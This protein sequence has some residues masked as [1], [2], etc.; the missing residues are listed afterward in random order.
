MSP[1][2]AQELLTRLN[3][4]ES[5]NATLRQDQGQARKPDALS[6]KVSQ[7]GAI[8]IYKLQRFPVTLYANQWKRIDEELIQSG[9]L[10]KFIEENRSTLAIKPTPKG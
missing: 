2:Q 5:E 4:L 1:E 3:I 7:K 10:D 9:A 8:S 6:M